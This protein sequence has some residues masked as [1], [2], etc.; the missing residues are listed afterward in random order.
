MP[1]LCREQWC[2]HL[3]TFSHISSNESLMQLRAAHL[4]CTCM[5][6]PVMMQH[7]LRPFRT[8]E[9]KS[10]AATLQR[11]VPTYSVYLVHHSKI[12][13]EQHYPLGLNCI[14]PSQTPSFVSMNTLRMRC[15]RGCSRY[16]VRTMLH[17]CRHWWN[18]CRR[19]KLK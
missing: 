5:M 13:L 15:I 8:K 16:K 14:R 9:Q 17:S 2:H 19:S 18:V 11:T 10:K 7:K 1:F 12:S 4:W 6:C 3:S